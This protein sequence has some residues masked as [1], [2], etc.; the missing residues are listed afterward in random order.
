MDLIGLEWVFSAAGRRVLEAL[1]ADAELSDATLLTYL[2]RL[3]REYPV[4]GVRAALEIAL[5]RR[6]AQTKFPQAE[7]MFFTREA[8]EQA[9]PWPVAAYRATRFAHCSTV[10]DLA[11]SIG[12]DALPLSWHT[13]VVAV[14]QDP[15]RLR[16]LEANVHALGLQNAIKLILHDITNIELPACDGIFFDPSRRVNGRRIWDVEA[17]LPPLSTLQRWADVP[18]RAAKVAP[19]IPDE[20]I[21]AECAV[22]FVSLDGAVRE[23]TLWWGAEAA[24]TRRAT[25]LRSGAAPLHLLADPHTPPALVAAAGRFLYEPDGTILRAHAVADLALLLEAWQLDAT[26]A[27]LS[28]DR[29]HVTPWA[30]VWEIEATLPFNLKA[31]RKELQARDVGSVTVKKRGSPIT[32]EQLQKQL[33]LRGTHHQIVVLTQVA[34]APTVLLCKELTTPVE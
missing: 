21:P 14:D 4:E 8:L 7:R 25:L 26:I 13:N 18:L 3:R 33:R 31:L 29:L 12:G 27:F 15:V 10:A 16:L 30:R 17:Y 23:A 19:G 32:P 28:S 6:A 20:Q 5:C 24:G 11:C 22:E 34:G 9:T 1:S 2:T